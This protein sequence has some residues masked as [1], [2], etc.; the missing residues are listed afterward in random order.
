MNPNFNFKENDEEYDVPF[1]PSMGPSLERWSIENTLFREDGARELVT[2]SLEK[3]VDRIREGID[4]I[5]RE[6]CFRGLRIESGF[7]YQQFSRS[8][9][10]YFYC[11]YHEFDRSVLNSVEKDNESYKNQ[12]R[13]LLRLPVKTSI[14]GFNEEQEFENQQQRLVDGL[15]MAIPE[16]YITA[17]LISQT[18]GDIYIIP[19]YEYLIPDDEFAEADKFWDKFF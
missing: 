18:E 16:F 12:E 1:E 10:L 13:V 14:K 4:S 3:Y 8:R 19:G 17:T 7:D 5:D 6:L 11:F 15:R 9:R 2:R